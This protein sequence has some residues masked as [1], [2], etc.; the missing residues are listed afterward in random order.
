M[1]NSLFIFA[2]CI[3]FN[4]LRA[5]TSIVQDADGKTSLSM[6]N[7]DS[8]VLNLNVADKGVTLALVDT[9]ITSDQILYWG[10]QLKINGKDGKF[11]TVKN[12]IANFQIELGVTATY[13]GRNNLADYFYVQGKVGVGRIKVATLDNTSLRTET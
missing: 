12:G 3:L 5:Q 11:P 8:I 10:G 4:Q 6:N 1:K 9:D 2:F 7:E 13:L